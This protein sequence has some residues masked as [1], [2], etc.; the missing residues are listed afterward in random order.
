MRIPDAGKNHSLILLTLLESKK[1]GVM[2]GAR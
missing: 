1:E 2:D